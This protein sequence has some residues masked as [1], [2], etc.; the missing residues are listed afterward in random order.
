MPHKRMMRR[1][2]LAVL[3]LIALGLFVAAVVPV[4]RLAYGL[5]V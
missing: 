4:L 1:A 2:A 5:A 3:G